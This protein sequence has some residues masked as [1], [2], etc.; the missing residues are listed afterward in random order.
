MNLP[1]ARLLFGH[2]VC[3]ID[4]VHEFVKACLKFCGFLFSLFFNLSIPFLTLEM[5]L[6]FSPSCLTETFPGLSC[7][8]QHP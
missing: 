1:N 6:S 5:L 4:F 3:N 2:P 7:L 8:I